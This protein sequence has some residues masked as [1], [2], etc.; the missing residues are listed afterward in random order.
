MFVVWRLFVSAV[1]TTKQ[2]QALFKDVSPTDWHEFLSAEVTQISFQLKGTHI[3]FR[4]VDPKH[5]DSSPSAQFTPAEGRYYCYGCGKY[6][7]DPIK[8]V[9]LALRVTYESALNKLVKR[10]NLRIS[11]DVA[12]HLESVE[13]T[14]LFKAD[15]VAVCRKNLFDAAS[16][17]ADTAYAYVAPAV[18]YL[19]SRNIQLDVAEAC[20]IGAFP[21]RDYL[22]NHL[23][24]ES[25]VVM[26][27]YLK[28][29][30]VDKPTAAGSY[31]GWLVLP[32]YT[33]PDRVGGIKLLRKNPSGDKDTIWL[34]MKEE[35]E[36]G[37]LGMQAY[38]K[39]VGDPTY[40]EGR[41]A[42]LVEGEFD[43]LSTFQGQMTQL[44]A[45]SAVVLGGSG[46][47]TAACE[48][49]TESGL[50]DLVVVPDNDKGG[51][52]FVLH[53][54]S[55]TSADAFESVRIFK[56]PAGFTG[57]DPDEAINKDGFFPFFDALTDE[58]NWATPQTWATDMVMDHGAMIKS[59]DA[60]AC[61]DLVKIYVEV[62]QNEVER[63]VF[64]EDVAEKLGV[65]LTVLRRQI[66]SIDTEDGYQ[67]AWKKVLDDEII[68]LAM[69]SSTRLLCFAKE[70]NRQFSVSLSRPRDAQ[71]ALITNVFKTDVYDWASLNIGE[72]EWL[73]TQVQGKISLPK[74]R[75]AKISVVEKYFDRALLELAASARPITEFES[76]G[77]GTHWA[78]AD[79]SPIDD[80]YLDPEEDRERLYLVNGADVYH[81][82]KQES[83][84]SF[85]FET[86]TAP[87]HGG[88][89]FNVNLKDRWSTEILTQDDLNI[90]HR[91]DL[92]AI[93][94]TLC[95][96]FDTG[97]KFE[98]H[99]LQVRF[100]AL[101]VFLPTIATVFNEFPLVLYNAPFASGKSKLLKG[102]I[103]GKDP[104]N[105]GLVEHSTGLD[106]FTSAAV[107][108]RFGGSSLTVC[109]DEFEAPDQNRTSKKAKAVK[110]FYEVV[111]NLATGVRQGRGSASGV[112]REIYMRF[113]L[114]AASIHP[115][116]DIVDYS[117]WV[118]LKPAKTEGK[119]PPEELILRKI[120]VDEISRIRRAL[121]LMPLQGLHEILKAYSEV[122]EEVY[123]EGKIPHPS[124][125]FTNA[126]LP[127][128]ALDKWIGN[129]YITFGKE[130]TEFYE[131]SMR[132][133][134][135]S[136]EE[137][138]FRS[139]FHTPNIRLAAEGPHVNRNAIDILN[140]PHSRLML[141][142]ANCGVYYFQGTDYVVLYPDILV[143]SLL[144][145][146][147]SLRGVQNPQT[148]LQRLRNHPK[149]H[150]NPD[151]LRRDAIMMAHLNRLSTA[152]P[153]GLLF[154][155]LKDILSG[156][157][158]SVDV[159]SDD[160]LSMSISM[161]DIAL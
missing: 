112:A 33:A 148:L 6:I 115:I 23:S 85:R 95:E 121:T 68:P 114:I 80:T 26:D 61:V 57:T 142:S 84:G 134:V 131:N 81:G 136:D 52:Q 104:K 123:V 36:L 141:S 50:L 10:F 109:L 100:L 117:R 4:C 21:T 67:A 32:Y 71:I 88:Y 132:E 19:L 124:P 37:F 15:F 139:V 160:M 145:A 78:S 122:R 108:Q 161:E 130:Y 22:F 28:A 42:Y 18:A 51:E 60:R 77:Q 53:R 43:F 83:D 103:W 90:P 66:S 44:P 8:V 135:M 49:L 111:R 129:D 24:V 106:D 126:M 158:D 30:L 45:P 87:V 93:Y 118:T 152:T 72:P 150:Y 138:L 119:V 120:S 157:E 107:T 56:W 29:Y 159:A 133:S 137:G 98:H 39:L 69:E 99:D 151:K 73:S 89:L 62:V 94:A 91:G 46:R 70:S 2:R 17:P 54:L 110:D 55:S 96:Y 155:Y 41:R 7:S 143:R 40:A 76:R 97:W 59:G 31:G 34:R 20:N 82:T 1:L 9:A 86:L 16:N 105:I 5:Q 92:K 27:D 75:E 14:N 102:A 127:M 156:G 35:G 140:D 74:S 13:R 116:Q 65:S 64:L 25:R 63:E 153:E 128:F 3:F 38:D 146:D 101:Y 48:I 79:E 113:P 12:Q 154:V 125:R 58:D 144:T 11:R 149:V 47:G 147:Q